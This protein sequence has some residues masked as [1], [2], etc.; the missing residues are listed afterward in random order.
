MSELT[1]TPSTTSRKLRVAAQQLGRPLDHTRLTAPPGWT[2]VMTLLPTSSAPRD[3]PV[4]LALGVLGDT[5]CQRSFSDQFHWPAFACPRGASDNIAA[6]IGGLSP[7]HQEW[8]GAH[9]RVRTHTHTHT[10]T[11]TRRKR[12]ALHVMVML[13]GRGLPPCSRVDRR[14]RISL[15]NSPTPRNLKWNTR[16]VAGVNGTYVVLSR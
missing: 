16:H 15:D 13:L 9:R 8:D 4:D 12:N 14:T 7:V 2:S 11:H 1:T 3:L 5:S 10:H 6:C